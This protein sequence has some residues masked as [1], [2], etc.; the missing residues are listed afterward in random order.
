MLP[1]ERTLVHVTPVAESREHAPQCRIP[2]IYTKWNQTSYIFLDRIYPA[3]RFNDPR[4]EILSFGAMALQ[5][6]LL[7]NARRPYAL[8]PVRTLPY[9]C[10]LRALYPSAL[11]QDARSIPE[12]CF[13][14]QEAIAES[15]TQPAIQ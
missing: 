5:K 6:A 13:Q 10:R 8:R 7:H 9:I 15:R 11:R 3:H 2:P 4:A 12:D 14:T 1:A